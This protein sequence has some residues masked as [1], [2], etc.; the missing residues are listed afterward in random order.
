MKATFT[1][2]SLALL[3]LL[4]SPAHA[5]SAFPLSPQDA[6]VASALDYLRSQQ[7]GDGS[8]GSGFVTAWSVMAIAATGQ[9]PH[10]WKA[11]SGRSPVDYLE[12]FTPRLRSLTDFER[13]TL[14]VTAAGRDP[15]TFAG[16]N[17]LTPILS[18]FDGQQFG[19]PSFLNDDAFAILALRSA[20][21]PASDARLQSSGAFLLANQGP[22][23]GWS[24]NQGGVSDADNTA[25]VLLALA[26]MGVAKEDAHVQAA[27]QWLDLEQAPDGGYQSLVHGGTA[28]NTASDAWVIQALVAYGEDPNGP[29]WTSSLGFTIVDNLLALQEA[30]GSFTWDGLQRVGPIWMTAYAV[31]ALVGETYPVN[32]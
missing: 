18:A 8:V 21:I 1:A 4:S 9:D 5:A 26:R 23:G 12:T 19:S 3:L 14:A 25:G 30:D 16:Q 13:H 7:L 15:T 28:S 6:P 32:L 29:A 22:D 2:A 27:L 24:W 17:L 31:T 11:F 20:G 10:T